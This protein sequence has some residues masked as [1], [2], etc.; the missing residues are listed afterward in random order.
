MNPFN[1]IVQFNIKTPK[2]M[3]LNNDLWDWTISLPC[4]EVLHVDSKEI[5]Y[6][7]FR[8]DNA[9]NGPEGGRP[10]FRRFVSQRNPKTGENN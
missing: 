4:Y 3:R 1:F 7:I 6:V 2:Q 9:S 8:L 5:G 10:D